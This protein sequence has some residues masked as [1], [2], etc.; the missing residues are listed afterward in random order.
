MKSLILS[1]LA[2]SALSLAQT[3]PNRYTIP[4]TDPG[5]P[6]R[7]HIES[8]NGAVH[9]EGH[10]GKDVILEVSTSGPAMKDRGTDAKGMKRFDLATAGLE[11]EEK[12]NQVKIESGGPGKVDLH[13]LVPAQSSVKVESVGGGELKIEGLTG[14]V[15]AEGVNGKIILT[16]LSGGVVSESVNGGIV[17]SFTQLTN[18]KP[19][20]LTSVNG[21]VEVTLPADVKAKV[22]LRSENGGVMSDFDLKT[23]PS[24][25]AATSNG[26]DKSGKFKLK[27][28]R[29]V[30]GSINGGGAEL[31]IETVNGAIYLKKK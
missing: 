20:S 25:M 15:E 5:R 4:L 29:S 31:R 21:P 3:T 27:L 17:A 8:V 19:V 11:A 16:N 22:K 24:D 28:D 7:V 6:A 13:V 2:V 12:N 23:D 14:G 30:N 9:V 1:A 18:D 26:R 10:A